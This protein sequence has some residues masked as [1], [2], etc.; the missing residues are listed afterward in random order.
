VWEV[1]AGPQ[2]G[3]VVA[4]VAATRMGLLEPWRTTPENSER[5][6]SE[7]WRRC[8]VQVVDPQEERGRSG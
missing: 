1:S 2:A 4:T 8:S 6:V 7:L 3:T 5:E